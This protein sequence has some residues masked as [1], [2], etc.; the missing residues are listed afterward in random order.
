MRRHSNMW[1]NGPV[2]GL[3]A[4]S[5]AMNDAFNIGSP[6]KRKER[7]GVLIGVF[8]LLLIFALSPR[9]AGTAYVRIAG[10]VV[11]GQVIEKHER[12]LMDG[13]DLTEHMLEVVYRFR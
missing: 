3:A 1:S 11:E 9:F 7:S 10:A 6:S 8:V 12:F 5:L 13:N 2:L 4:R